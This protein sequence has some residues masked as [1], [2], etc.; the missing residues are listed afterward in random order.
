MKY[1]WYLV[2]LLLLLILLSPCGFLLPGDIGRW[3]GELIYGIKS[4]K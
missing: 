2:L 3:F 1:V 4:V